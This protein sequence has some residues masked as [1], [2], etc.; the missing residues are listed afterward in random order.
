MTTP[1][2]APV[3]NLPFTHGNG[4]LY[5]ILAGPATRPSCSILRRP[6]VI[7]AFLPGRAWG[8]A[9]PS[10]GISSADSIKAYAVVDLWQGSTG[11][12]ALRFLS[13]GTARRRRSGH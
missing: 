7:S 13:A 12:P 4:E 2:M 8:S 1:I 3:P 10:Y 6:G 11:D 5:L 9:G